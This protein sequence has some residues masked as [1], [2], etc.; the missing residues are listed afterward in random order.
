MS[1]ICKVANG[2][3]EWKIGDTWYVLSQLKIKRLKEFATWARNR[4]I[5]ESLKDLEILKIDTPENRYKIMKELPRDGDLTSL[6][7]SELLTTEGL[8]YALCLSINEIE[9]KVKYE[10]VFA[11]MKIRTPKDITALGDFIVTGTLPKE[12]TEKEEKEEKGIGE[13]KNVA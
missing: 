2:C 12:K 1:D 8:A 3:L 11:E 5:K 6:I 9:V 7:F 10:D 4:R 13:Q